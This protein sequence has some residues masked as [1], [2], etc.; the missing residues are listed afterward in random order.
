MPFIFKSSFDKANRSLASRASAA[1]GMEEGLRILS[2]VKKP[3]AACRSLTDV[4]EDT[5]LGEVA[6]GRRRDA[7][8]GVPGSPD[9]L[10]RER[11]ARRTGP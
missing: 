11:A 6:V 2:E 3:A 10:H 9:Q 8:A 7:D 4:H 1:P 5:P